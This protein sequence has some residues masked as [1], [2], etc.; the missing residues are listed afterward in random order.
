MKKE[1]ILVLLLMFMTVQVSA[2][3]EMHRVPKVPTAE[4]R[5]KRVTETLNKTLNLTAKQQ[6]TVTEAYKNFFA[7]VDKLHAPPPPPPAREKIEPFITK[8]DNAIKAVLTPDAFKQYLE[9]EKSLRP[10]QPPH[11]A[12]PNRP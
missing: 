9:L 1:I 5:L 6:Q 4:E 7:E 10:Q 3:T 2:Q 12:K 11:A 8:R